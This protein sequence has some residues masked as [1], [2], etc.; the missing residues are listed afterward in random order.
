M[1]CC[2]FQLA[3]TCCSGA[4][5]SAASPSALWVPIRQALPSALA[6]HSQRAHEFLGREELA[7]R[8]HDG[9]EGAD[10]VV[11]LQPADVQR[12]RSQWHQ[13]RAEGVRLGE[14]FEHV[15]A[16]GG[17]NAW[18][19][20]APRPRVGDHEPVAECT[21]P[22]YFKLIALPSLRPACLALTFVKSM[23]A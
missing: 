21:V 4:A 13:G 19:G 5:N 7:V 6:C 1:R 8:G 22:V 23:S 12:G 3:P 10:A 17:T 2:L 14:A 15:L 11:E 9:V 18:R 20:A 16:L